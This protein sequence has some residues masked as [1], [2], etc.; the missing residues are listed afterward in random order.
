MVPCDGVASRRA[1]QDVI[2]VEPLDDPEAMKRTVVLAGCTPV[3][4]L[5]A[6]AAERWYPGLRVHWTFANSAESLRSV[7]D[8][9]VHAAGLHVL[10]PATGEYN[11]PYVRRHLPH[12][13]VVLINLGVWEEGLLLQVG[14]PK[15]IGRCADLASPGVTVI[16]REE[17]A[18]SRLLLE[19]TLRGDGVPFDAVNGFDRLAY[20][21]SEVAEVVATGK[22]DAGVSSACI[23]AAYGLHFLPFREAR[24]DLALLKE[25]LEH[26]P[27]RQLLGTLG[28]RWV[29]SQ[30]AVLGGYDTGR[31]GEIVAE[32]ARA[33]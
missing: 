10:D 13:D 11:T 12:R 17:G 18:G 24:Y 31:T 7:A 28:H 15:G 20:S 14:N 25:H 29:R 30:L 33:A 3:L 8:G 27:V 5:W 6:R 9:E 26:E 16:N 21:H 2:E 19:E 4:S 23:A 22:A 32:V 1:S